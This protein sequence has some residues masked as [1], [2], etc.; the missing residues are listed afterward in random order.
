MSY[1]PEAKR[2]LWRPQ[3]RRGVLQAPLD[4]EI[5]VYHPDGMTAFALNETASVI[6]R[7]CNGERTV[8]EIVELL[9][10]AYP[11]T[12]ATMSREVDEGILA[13][14]S[15]GVIRL[16]RVGA[17]AA[18]YDVGFGGATVRLEAD[19]AAAARILEFLCA[20]MA[21][22]AAGD[23]S[24]TF[25]LGAATTP[26]ALAIYQ[27]DAMLY[28]SRS[29][30]SVAAIFLERVLEHLIRACTGGVLLHAAAVA[31]AG[32]A[33]VLA[34]KTGAGK[35]TLA[36]WL[37]CRGFDYLSDELLCLD[38]Q[39][40]SVNGFA[41]PLHL[42]KP[43]RAL[44]AGVIDMD[45]GD[46]VMESPLGTHV[47]PARIGARVVR[48]ARPCALVLPTYRAGARFDMRP[49]SK[50]QAATRLMGSLVNAREQPQHGFEDVLGAVHAV[51]AF[52]M[53]YSDL[54][55]AGAELEAVLGSFA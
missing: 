37:V 17:S 53:T 22:P 16:P 36:T 3:Q 12:A 5:L 31:R 23:P 42:K 9:Q 33:L 41:R 26:G 35:T 43:A 13:L 40:M 32:K 4:N 25:R 18:T 10:T 27:D 49:L 28:R 29:E 52:A 54:E 15:H 55:E 7:L 19:D 51:P 46:A 34:G 1:D 20:P 45:G 14:L 38:T 24:A 39:A 11:E 6:W 47:S 21:L 2:S 48:V 44:F 8:A 30:S 50:A